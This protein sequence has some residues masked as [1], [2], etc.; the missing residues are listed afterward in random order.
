LAEVKKQAASRWINAVN[1]EGRHGS[2]EFLMVRRVGEVRDA[3][4]AAAAS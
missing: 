1:A 4:A 2:W 3:I